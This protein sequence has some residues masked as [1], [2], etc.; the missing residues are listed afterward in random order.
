M[1]TQTASGRST[2]ALA[3]V[4]LL[5]GPSAAQTPLG[6]AFT[7]QGRLSDGGSLA[8]GSFDF[9]FLLFDAAG[10]GLQVGSTLDHLAVAVTDGLFTVSLD[11]GAS[12]FAGSARWLEVHVRP[13]GGGA[14]TPLAGRQRL[15]PTPY[16]L[17]A[18]GVVDG[19]IVD[20]D[21]SPTASLSGSKLADGSVTSAKVADG[22]GSGLDADVFD[23]LNSSQFLRSDTSGTLAGTLTVNSAGGADAVL[24]ETGIDR[25]LAGPATFTLSNS[26][27]GISSTLQLQVESGTAAGA[28]AYSFA[29][30]PDTGLLRS[31]EDTLAFAIGGTPVVTIGVSGLSATT[32]AITGAAIRGTGP[33]GSFGTGVHGAN[34]SSG[35]GIVAVNTSSGTALVVASLTGDHLRADTTESALDSDPVLR[36]TNGGSLLADGTLA[37]GSNVTTS[38]ASTFNSFGNPASKSEANIS[39]ANDVYVEGGLEVD[40]NGYVDGNLFLGGVS[41]TDNDNI[42]FDTGTDEFLRWDDTDFRFVL[43]RGLWLGGTLTLDPNLGDFTATIRSTPGEGLDIRTDNLYVVSDDD[44]NTIADSDDDD[45]GDVKW[46]RP[47]AILPSQIAELR[48]TGAV[49]DHGDLL[50]RGQLSTGVSSFDVAERFRASEDVEPGDLV[51]VDPERR[52]AV[53]RTSGEGDNAVLGVVSTDPALLIGGTTF[54]AGALRVWGE[55][56]EQAF[57]A[58]KD[59]L[60]AEVLAERPALQAE[61]TR[62]ETA[63]AA[64]AAR[65]PG[66]AA[67]ARP[68]E[69][70]RGSSVQGKIEQL[71]IER[72]AAR[73]LAAVA[74]AGRLPV[75]VNSSYGDIRVGDMLAPSPTPGVA[76]RATR[77]GPIVGTA[78]ENFSGGRSQVLTFVHRG[79]YTAPADVQAANVAS[80]ALPVRAAA[81]SDPA[82]I[83]YS[84]NVILDER[85]EAE[86]ELP[87]GPVSPS[88]DFR[89]QLTAVGAP[90][91]GLYV[92]SKV[93]GN[94]FRIAGGAPGL[95]VSW[96]VSGTSGEATPSPASVKSARREGR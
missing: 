27:A 10:G 26:D 90:G 77:S 82:T 84:G 95:E 69:T 32:S 67:G 59:A 25:S 55:D 64:D 96:H 28:P 51:R 35:R 86:V 16:A 46:L 81:T 76:M 53:L 87:V 89:Y 40:G 62:V 14:Y 9:Q 93:R 57:Q 39:S 38:T 43:S 20:A 34:N 61:L 6:T 44:A 56:L 49:A 17:T 11:F 15:T 7:Y 66:R 54:D 74:L 48:A 80:R 52:D 29:G 8:G 50:I 13:A 91:P 19:A 30:D 1:T 42:Y 4:C 92:A 45:V 78:L 37:V 31:A 24:A 47:G 22:A 73:R 71:A 65:V 88:R 72:F 3:L 75:K 70:D 83:G 2:F 33:G 68:G 23:G 85:G 12:A 60:R 18:A 58:Q 21:V 63:L 94:R 5:A 79:Y 41:D 36:I